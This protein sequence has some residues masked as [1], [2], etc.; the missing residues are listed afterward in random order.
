MLSKNGLFRPILAPQKTHISQK[1]MQNSKMA[2]YTLIVFLLVQI[3]IYKLTVRCVRA[4]KQALLYAFTSCKIF[5]L[6]QRFR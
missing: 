4:C 6:L 1:S 3:L 5:K 2:N